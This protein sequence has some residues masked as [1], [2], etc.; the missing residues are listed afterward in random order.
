M[1]GEIHRLTKDG[2]LPIYRIRETDDGFQIG[3]NEEPYFQIICE[4][5]DE[6]DAWEIADALNAREQ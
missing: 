6:D 1:K 5:T 2:K 3:F 4:V